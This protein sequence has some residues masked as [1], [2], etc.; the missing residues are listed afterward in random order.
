MMETKGSNEIPYIFPVDYRMRP[1]QESFAFDPY[2]NYVGVMRDAIEKLDLDA[3]T[4]YKNRA[5]ICLTTP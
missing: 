2:V 1:F 3:L 4:G 5:T